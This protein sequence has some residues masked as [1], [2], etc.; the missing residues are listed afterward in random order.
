MAIIGFGKDI[1]NLISGNQIVLGGIKFDSQ[2]QIQAHSDG[3]VV[4]H[5]LSNAILS[6]LCLDDIGCYFSDKD[7]KNKNLNS[8][9]ILDFCLEKL[10]KSNLYFRNIAIC[11]T[12]QQIKINPLKNKIIKNLQKKLAPYFKDKI[13]ISLH[14]TS[15]ENSNNYQ[16]Q[17]DCIIN[18]D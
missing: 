18:L 13:L 10:K 9:L 1:H 11:I 16:I 8:E 14:A 2:F 6:S 17:S 5:S 4:L 12:C 3:D 15:F 7:E